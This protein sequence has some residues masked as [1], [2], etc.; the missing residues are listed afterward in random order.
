MHRLAG[1]DAR[2]L[3]V[4]NGA[5]GRIDGALAVDRI[6]DGVDDAPQQALADRNINN[7]AGPLD[8]IPFADHSVI[9]EQHDA[10]V[11]LFEVQRHALGAVGK[12]DHLAGLHLVQTMDA[13]NAVADGENRADLGDLRFGAERGDLLLQDRRN[14]SGPDLHLPDPLHGKA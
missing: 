10:D 7:I 11:V 2:R 5:L 13:G 14:F 9:A 1:N 3:D 6:T 4:G 12:L 8:D